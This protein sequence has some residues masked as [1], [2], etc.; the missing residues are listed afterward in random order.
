M[1]LLV[2]VGN[3][4]FIQ[5]FI[6]KCFLVKIFSM[7][8]SFKFLLISKRTHCICTNITALLMQNIEF[9]KVDTTAT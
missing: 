9:L 8:M 5:I 7:G 2:T 4:A 6:L 1:E 3:S